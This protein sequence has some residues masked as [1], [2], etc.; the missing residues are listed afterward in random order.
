MKL[1]GSVADWPDIKRK[2][3]LRSSETLRAIVNYLKDGGNNA[4]QKINSN[5]AQTPL[6]GL[7]DVMGSCRNVYGIRGVEL[8]MRWNE[9]GKLMAGAV[10]FCGRDAIFCGFTDNNLGMEHGEVIA[11]ALYICSEAKTPIAECK[12]PYKG[13]SSQDIR[14]PF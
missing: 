14:R 11:R 13:D 2:I 12:L 1:H 10:C 4:S 8:S 7:R 5:P 9:G 6:S 3:L